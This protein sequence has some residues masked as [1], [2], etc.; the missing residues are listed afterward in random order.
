MKLPTLLS[1]S[2]IAS[3]WDRSRQYVNNVSR[4]D[5]SF[6]KEVM[7][8]DNGRMPLFLETDIESYEKDKNYKKDAH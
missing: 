5:S 7:R 8:V 4:R 2:D 3:R 6:P 1:K